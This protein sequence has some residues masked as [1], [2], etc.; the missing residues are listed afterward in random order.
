MANATRYRYR[1]NEQVLETND[2][3][4]TGRDIRAQSDLVPVSDY[5]LI[6]LGDR[7][8]RSIGLE[9]SIELSGDPMP[10][11]LS[12]S[13]D[14][15][16]SLTINERGYEWGAEEIP[17]SAIR[18]HAAI[19]DD[20]ELILDSE[21]DRVL[22]DDDVV[23]LKGKGVERVRSRPAELICIIVNTRQKF[24]APGRI[25]FAQLVALAFPDLPIGPN[26]AFTVSF[27]KGRGDKPEGTLI[28]GESIKVKKG[29]VFNV[30]ATD[31]A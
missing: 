26:T 1:L 11:F 16:F 14:Q 18:L 5:I 9:E 31:K 27:R 25:S 17:V 22:E 20:H 28:E 15:V 19:P 8:T 10:E 21:G 6:E 2:P 3:V 12:F 4:V 23:R 29:M 24:V 13:G 30:S 7:T